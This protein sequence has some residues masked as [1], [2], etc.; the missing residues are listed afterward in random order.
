MGYYGG[1]PGSYYPPQGYGYGYPYNPC[2]YKG[3]KK[4]NTG[5]FFALIVLLFILFVIVGGAGWY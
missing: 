5:F 4:G 1:Y 2:C 3:Q